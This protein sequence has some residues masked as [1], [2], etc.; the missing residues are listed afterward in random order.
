MKER[1][2]DLLVQLMSEMQVNPRLSERDL[3]ELRDK[4]FTQSEIGE[5]LSWLH[6]NLKF[7]NGSILLP[8]RRPAGSKRIFH[9]AEKSAL[10]VQSQGYLI[11]LRELG[12]LDDRD[13]EA[14]I[15]RAMLSGY[16]KLSVEEIREIAATVLFGKQGM[17]VRPFLNNSDSI[18]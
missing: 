8:S 14:V 15:E 18:H 16:E 4:G 6:D 11:Q 9:D 2:V 10:T 5:A 17:N 3:A 12:L 7:E 1:I 13:L